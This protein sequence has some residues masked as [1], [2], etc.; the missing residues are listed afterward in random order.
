MSRND[1][2]CIAHNLPQVNRI[3]LLKKLPVRLFQRLGVHGVAIG[4]FHIQRHWASVI[5]LVI[6][7]LEGLGCRKA[8][9]QSV[10][11]PETGYAFPNTSEIADI[12]VINAFMD[13]EQKLPDFDVP[14]ETWHE[15]ITSLTPSQTDKEA[16]GWEVMA[17]LDIK[18][19]HEGSCVVTLFNTSPQPIGAFAI[20]LGSAKASY[21]RGGNSTKI[22]KIIVAAYQ[23]SGKKQDDSKVIKG[24]ARW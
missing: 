15:I 4:S 21:Y 9:L 2:Q 24:S 23:A 6:L 7:A 17:V 5:I 19:K 14:F 20:S 10:T 3:S 1:G 8:V 11:Y 12:R 13:A 18:T 16:L 22:R